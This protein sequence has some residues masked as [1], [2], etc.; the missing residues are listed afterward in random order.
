MPVGFWRRRIHG[1]GRSSAV[2]RARVTTAGTKAMG[3]AAAAATIGACLMLAPAG[4]RRTAEPITT[5]QA[6]VQACARAHRDGDVDAIRALSADLRELEDRGVS[7]EA[8]LAL[9]HEAD[10][11]LRGALEHGLAEG[12]GPY[13]SW[14]RAEYVDHVDH[15]DHL[16]VTVSTMGARA[17]IV[18]VWQDG[19]LRLHPQPSWFVCPSER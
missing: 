3:A 14:A 1:A 4:C 16:H 5:P 6:F 2:R 8:R 18:L 11:L 7:H 9:D 12:R 17:G 13:R 19:T 10:S 15:G